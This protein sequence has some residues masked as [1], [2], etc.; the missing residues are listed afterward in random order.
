VLGMIQFVK[1]LTYCLIP[2]RNVL[3]KDKEIPLG[4]VVQN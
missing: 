3:L 4:E 1:V 2:N